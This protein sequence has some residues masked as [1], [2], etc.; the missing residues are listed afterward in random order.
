MIYRYKSPRILLASVALMSG[1]GSASGGEGMRFVV[2]AVRQLSDVAVSPSG[3]EAGGVELGAELVEGASLRW[4]DGKVC[5]SWEKEEAACEPLGMD[6]PMLADVYFQIGESA[7]S[8]CIRYRATAGDVGVVRIVDEQ[9]RLIAA[10]AGSPAY[11]L[12]RVLSAA[13]GL[14]LEEALVERKF[15]PGT[16][17]GI[18]DEKTRTALG[19]YLEYRGLEYRF[20]TPVVSVAVFEELVGRAP[21]PLKS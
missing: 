2:V 9:L 17:D 10:P 16:V 14:A 4:V 3:I 15:D 11:V 1:L 21:V 12:E 19:F 5:E 6:D 7:E 18:I 13:D 8:R 20:A